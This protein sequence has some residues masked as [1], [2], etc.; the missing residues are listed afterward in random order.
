MARKPSRALPS[1]LVPMRREKYVGGSNQ[2]AGQFGPQ[3][4]TDE[5]RALAHAYLTRKAPDLLDVLGL[6]ELEQ[7]PERVAP[8][9]ARLR[10]VKCP[11][12]GAQPGQPCVSSQAARRN[13]ATR[14]TSHQE[15]RDYL[16]RTE[17]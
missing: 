1:D 14:R 8:R 17:S 12:C 5:D 11:D 9:E 13:G 2:V 3:T 10:T 7:V 4:C 16:E 6:A 15:R